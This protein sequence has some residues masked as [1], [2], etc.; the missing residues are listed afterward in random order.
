MSDAHTVC[1]GLDIG[2]GSARALAVAADGAVVGRGTHPLRSRRD[3]RIV[4]PYLR[5]QR[6]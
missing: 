4:L 3:T 5:G 2:T 1:V 6:V